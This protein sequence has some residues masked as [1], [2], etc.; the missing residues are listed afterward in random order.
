MRVQLQQ[1]Y[2]LHARRYR[3]SSRIVEMLTPEHGLVS[4]LGHSSKK[5]NS[6]VDLLFT[7]LLV[8]WSGRG[9]LFTLTHVEG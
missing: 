9:E 6:S 8:S 2:C 3:E 4:C 7:P 1:A 5:K